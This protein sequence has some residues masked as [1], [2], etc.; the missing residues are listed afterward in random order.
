MDKSFAEDKNLDVG[1][2]FNLLT[3]S[4]EQTPLEVKGIYE[5]PPFYPLLGNVSILQSRFDQL[6]DLPKNQ[7]TFVNVKGEPDEQIENGA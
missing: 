4:G 1:S 5:A 3:E 6:Y 2:R 7:F